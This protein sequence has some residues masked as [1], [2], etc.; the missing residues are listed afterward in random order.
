VAWRALEALGRSD[1]AEAPH[2]EAAA[3]AEDVAAN[4]SA[5]LRFGFTARPD[6]A[7]LIA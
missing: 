5:E 7:E 4:A 6:V 2:K 3:W 1:E